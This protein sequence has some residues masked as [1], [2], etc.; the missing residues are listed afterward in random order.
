MNTKA[1]K[2]IH[3]HTL[4]MKKCKQ[5]AANIHSKTE[6]ADTNICTYKIMHTLRQ[7]DKQ[8]ILQTLTQINTKIHRYTHAYIH[9]HTEELYLGEN[10][11]IINVLNIFKRRHRIYFIELHK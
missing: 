4:E 2:H 3:T 5:P 7:I 8:I 6:H 9:I 10:S 11:K 1:H